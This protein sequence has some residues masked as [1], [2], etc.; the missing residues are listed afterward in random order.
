MVC[1]DV[2]GAVVAVLSVAVAIEVGVR[3]RVAVR[4]SEAVVD[5]VVAVGVGVVASPESVLVPES[6]IGVSVL[7][8]GVVPSLQPAR[9]KRATSATTS[10]SRFTR[11]SVSRRS[12]KSTEALVM[13]MARGR[14]TIDRDPEKPPRGEGGTGDE[15]GSVWLDRLLTRLVLGESASVENR[16]GSTPDGAIDRDPEKPRPEESGV[17]NKRGF[18]SVDR[19]VNWLV[20]GDPDMP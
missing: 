11:R 19:L 16:D 9:I 2:E 7:V 14:R 10:N 6:P 17:W 3:V 1:P 5:V 15:P 8:A 18:R 20:T 13:D 12:F 4:H